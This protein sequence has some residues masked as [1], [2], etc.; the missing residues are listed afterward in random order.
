[1]KIKINKKKL[2]N[3]FLGFLLLYFYYLTLKYSS[4]SFKCPIYMLFDVQCPGCGISRMY[5]NIFSFNF[6]EAFNNNQLIFILQP[7]LYYFMGKIIINYIQDKQISYSKLENIILCIMI[8]LLLI[9]G[10]LRN[11]F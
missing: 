11:I 8:V 3:V 1:M 5:K 4:F 10:I 9:F 7:F 6:K 2:L